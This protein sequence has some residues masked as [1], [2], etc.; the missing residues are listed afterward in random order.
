MTLPL[1]SLHH[2]NKNLKSKFKT[3]IYKFLT[4]ETD[5]VPE[6]Y[7]NWT[8]LHRLTFQ[9]AT[10]STPAL[11]AP[12]PPAPQPPPRGA[13][14]QASSSS[15]H[16]SPTPSTSTQGSSFYTACPIRSLYFRYSFQ[17]RC[18]RAGAS[19]HKHVAKVRKMTLAELF[20]GNFK[21]LF[22][23]L[24]YLLKI[25]QAK[26]SPVSDPEIVTAEFLDSIIS[27]TTDNKCLNIDNQQCWSLKLR[28][29]LTP[30]NWQPSQ[31]LLVAV[32][33]EHLYYTEQYAH[34][35]ESSTQLYTFRRQK[36]I[37]DIRRITILAISALLLGTN[38][39]SEWFF[40]SLALGF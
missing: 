14:K 5:T 11:P 36:T 28:S 3:D 30:H 21:K 7:F 20:P 26:S 22:N 15:Q 9:S 32:L 16:S 12:A 39:G 2:K 19:M 37:K 23:V 38:L 35:M 34:L 8:S 31:Q 29:P 18:S 33:E 4:E 24:H 13:S 6:F 10:S 40:S 25:T 17:K 1:K 27:S